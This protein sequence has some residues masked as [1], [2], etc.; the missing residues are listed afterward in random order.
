MEAGAEDARQAGVAN[1][2]SL[3][4]WERLFSRAV[5]R[6][7]SLAV[8]LCALAACDAP[9][10]ANPRLWT[11]F[12]V[13]ALYG[14][15]AQG[16]DAIATDAGLP[17]G[18]SL[19]SLLE[20]APSGLL[21]VHPA[22]AEGYSTGYVTTEVWTHFDEIWVQPMYLPATATN[23]VLSPVRDTD[24]NLHPIFSVGPGSAFYSPFWQT[25][26]VDVPAGFVD[27]TLTSERQILDGHYPLV[28]AKGWVA[29][30]TPSANL[31]PDTAVLPSGG[32]TPGRGWIDGAPIDY[33]QFPSAPFEW[34]D[35]LTVVEVPIFHF[36]FVKGDGTLVAPD[37]PSVLGT[38]PLFSQTPPPVDMNNAAT[39]AY[40]AYWRVYTVTVPPGGRVFAPTNATDPAVMSYVT[41][42]QNAGIPTDLPGGGSYDPMIAG[43]TAADLADYLGRVAVNGNCF[44]D[45]NAA[46]PHGGTCQYLDSQADIEAYLGRGAIQRTDITVTCPLVS[47]KGKAVGP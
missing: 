19:G 15:G 3:G 22:W 2:I 24:G 8:A 47:F 10:P 36:V 34:T 33:L 29:P 20:P 44:S 46:D 42:L 27:G 23:G 13:D 31:A 25:F 17:G 11:L 43:F 18:V 9:R 41:A 6:A 40:S 16:A 28:A 37:I 1:T 32:T 39:P 12:D 26:Y 14:G 30:L 5:R 7:G 4:A 45:I 38:G 21:Y 35:D